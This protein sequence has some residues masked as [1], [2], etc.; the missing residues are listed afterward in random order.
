MSYKRI[1]IPIALYLIGVVICYIVI[2][3]Q[4]NDKNYNYSIYRDVNLLEKEAIKCDIVHEI[5]NYI[6]SVAPTSCINGLAVFDACQEYNIDIIFVLAQGH[7]ESHFGTTGLAAKTNSVFNVLA[8]DNYTLDD[9]KRRKGT[10]SHPDKSIKPYL[11]LL[12]NNYLVD[13]R[14]ELDMLE[15]FVDKNGNRYASNPN[16]EANLYSLYKKIQ[17]NT[18]ISELMKR[19]NKYQIITNEF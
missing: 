18:R 9:I 17:D 1:F 2:L 13:G 8:Y 19:Y 6:Q 3:Q 14:H 5:D 7:L 10:Y 12:T 15:N 4:K 16:Y 11:D